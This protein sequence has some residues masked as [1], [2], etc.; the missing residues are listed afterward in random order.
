MNKFV[1]IWIVIFFLISL[2]PVLGLEYGGTYELFGLKLPGEEFEYNSIIYISFAAVILIFGILKASRR[3]MGMR[4]A[5]Q[6]EKFIFSAPVSA[7]RKSRIF[8][9]GILETAVLL[10]GAYFYYTISHLTLSVAI[11]LLAMA[12]EHVLH[13][14]IGFKTNS[15][16]V[17]ITQKAIVSNDRDVTVMY[18]SGLRKVGIHQQTVY[19]DYIKELTLHL[20][21]N[22]IDEQHWNAFKNTLKGQVNEERVFFNQAFKDYPEYTTENNIRTKTEFKPAAKEV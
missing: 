4:I 13:L 17:G 10:A 7:P 15:F 21:V 20:P 16:R 14:L 1:N 2:P 9:Y 5:T 12:A 8:T 18:F 22:C 3:W 11:V 6:T 19:F